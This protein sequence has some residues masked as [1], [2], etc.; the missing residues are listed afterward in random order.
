[1][2]APTDWTYGGQIDWSSPAKLKLLPV[3]MPLRCIIEALNERYAAHG[4]T[5]AAMIRTFGEV[6][7]LAPLMETY[8]PLAK[9]S[10][11][12]KAVQWCVTRMIKGFGIHD[13]NNYLKHTAA[14]GG[15]FT[16]LDSK[17]GNFPTWSESDML[18][19]IGA[20]KRIAV[21]SLLA[22]L[23]ADWFFQQYQ[24]LNLMRWIN[25]SP[26]L[27]VKYTSYTRGSYQTASTPAAA[28]SAAIGEVDAAAWN[29]AWGGGWIA[30]NKIFHYISSDGFADINQ[31]Y[32]HV[33]LENMSGQPAMPTP[34]NMTADL[35]VR[36]SRDTGYDVY[37]SNL[38]YQALP[39]V[40]LQENKT[41]RLYSTSLSAGAR[42]E[43]ADFLPT[44]SQPDIPPPNESRIKSFEASF[45]GIVCKL[46]VPGGFKFIA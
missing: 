43:L 18:A 28:W 44:P 3:Q 7:P 30:G 8:N 14:T 21:P 33:S 6:T 15:D 37:G 20:E 17:A 36:C 26:L 35:Y 40:T 27:D 1:M 10:D 42:V 29:T 4:S 19:A 13:M 25:W 34:F 23:S 46:D 39:G 45:M 41:N 32:T 16:G 9:I 38:F 22:P 24:L 31:R 12:A 2:D 5:A 11:Y